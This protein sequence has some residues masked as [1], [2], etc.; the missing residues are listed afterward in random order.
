VAQTLVL[1]ESFGSLRG[2]GGPRSATVGGNW[3]GETSIPHPAAGFPRRSVPQS[4][5]RSLRG[6]REIA[7]DGQRAR[8]PTDWAVVMRR[9]ED[10]HHRRSPRTE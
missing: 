9:S 3:K 10:C 1:I 4:R 2:F 6:G 5:S 8:R 7:W